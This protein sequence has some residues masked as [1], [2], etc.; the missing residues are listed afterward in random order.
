MCCSEARA[1]RQFDIVWKVSIYRINIERGLPSIPWHLGAIRLLMQVLNE[2]FEVYI[3]Y[4]NRTYRLRV[5][6]FF[7]YRYRIE[8]LS[9]SISSTNSQFI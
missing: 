4:R 7:V 3:K 1:P 8:L 6:S 5:R 9:R 2:S